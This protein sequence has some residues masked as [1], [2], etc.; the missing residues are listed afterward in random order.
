MRKID[1]HIKTETRVEDPKELDS[2]MADRWKSS[3]NTT[4]QALSQNLIRTRADWLRSGGNKLARRRFAAEMKRRRVKEWKEA[5]PEVEFSSAHLSQARSTADRELSELTEVKIVVL[6]TPGGRFDTAIHGATLDTPVGVN[7]YVM[8]PKELRK[9][10]RRFF[11]EALQEAEAQAPA[12]SFGDR[13]MATISVTTQPDGKVRAPVPKQS[14][15]SKHVDLRHLKQLDVWLATGLSAADTV[16]LEDRGAL[17]FENTFVPV[18]SLSVGPSAEHDS[19]TSPAKAAGFQSADFWHLT[20]IRYQA[21]RGL[22]GKGV[23][24]GVAD[25]GCDPDHPELDGKIKAFRAFGRNGR[26]L[27]QAK[28]RDFGNHGTHV[29]ALAAGARMGVARDADL[30][31]AAVLIERDDR[32]QMG[33]YI[34]Q[35]LAGLNWLLQGG[36]GLSQPVDIVNAS[37]GIGGYAAAYYASLSNARTISGIQVVA[38]IGN[39][40]RNGMG[41]HTSPGNYDICLGVGATNADDHSCAYSDWGH[42]AAH[43]GVSKP[44]LSAP[45]D[46]IWSAAPGGGYRSDSGTSMAAPLVAGTAALLMEAHP[47]LRDD[48]DAL[49]KALKKLT[50]AL[51]PASATRGG[52]GRVDLSNIHSI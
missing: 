41:N 15:R 44:D 3:S 46:R 38:A 30:A 24:I 36:E 6:P 10:G 28:A 5:H 31:V 23:V 37:F 16:A 51:D 12:L 20:K 48:P 4:V 19:T 45:G 40:G 34:A 14:S 26:P 11:H 27:P 7:K 1:K 8:Q 29:A 42:V 9:E 43:P 17:V 13:I 32:G 2:K 47:A 35:I 18:P 52:A 25:T 39:G 22:S 33:G 21:A 50:V 49:V